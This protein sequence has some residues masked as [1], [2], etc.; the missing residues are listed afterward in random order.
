M[1]VRW[2]RHLVIVGAHQ[3][4]HSTLIVV[5]TV[6]CFKYSSDCQGNLSGSQELINIITIHQIATI[7]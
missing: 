7:I 2:T 5:V 4:P 1:N 3:H 6:L